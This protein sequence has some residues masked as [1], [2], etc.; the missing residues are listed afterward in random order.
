L[1]GTK[2]APLE[3]KEIGGKTFRLAPGI[4]ELPKL[5]TREERLQAQSG[6]ARKWGHGNVPW[7]LR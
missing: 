7:F 2:E 3:R 5:K 4:I 6:N 1:E